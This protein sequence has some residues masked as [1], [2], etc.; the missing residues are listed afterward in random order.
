MHKLEKYY[1]NKISLNQK[2]KISYQ[3]NFKNK[4]MCK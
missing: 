2:N 1:I 3:D 4:K